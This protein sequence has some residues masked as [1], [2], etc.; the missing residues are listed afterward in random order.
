MTRPPSIVRFE[1]C[2]LG[3]LA[4]GAVN[5]AL[6]WSRYLA[7]PAVR[8]AQVTIG[9]WYLPTITVA[10]FLIPIALWYFAARRGSVVAKWIVVVL[11]GFGAFGLLA[12]FALGSMAP[13]LGAVLSVA[14]FVLN[15]VAVWMLF[16]VDAR[17]WFGETETETVA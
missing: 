4:I 2:Y 9:A 5:S 14:T 6:N 3:A 15:A 1:L 8:D 13:G 11:F 17:A 16:R 7:M 12:G 10:G